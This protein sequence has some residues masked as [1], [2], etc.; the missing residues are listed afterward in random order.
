MNLSEEEAS[1]T[2]KPIYERRYD[3]DWLRIVTLTK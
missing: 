3:I 1:T 2:T